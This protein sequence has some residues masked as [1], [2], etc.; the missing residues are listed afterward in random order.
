MARFGHGDD[1][2][3]QLKPPGQQ[4]TKSA[5]LLC[6]TTIRAPAPP[7]LAAR[8]DPPGAA[9]TRRKKAGYAGLHV[10]MVWWVELC[11]LG[12]LCEYDY[13]SW[14]SGLRVCA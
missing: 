14:L 2:V 10:V 9:T 11:F 7:L 5:L 8:L 1:F 4:S 12:E 3:V 6:S 13:V